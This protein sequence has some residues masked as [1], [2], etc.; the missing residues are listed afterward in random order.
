MLTVGGAMMKKCRHRAV[1]NQDLGLLH[2]I[3]AGMKWQRRWGCQ[4]IL[5]KSGKDIAGRQHQQNHD[6]SGQKIES[7][8]GASIEL[9]GT[10]IKIS[11]AEVEI[12]GS[13]KV[14]VKGR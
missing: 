3:T 8:A 4:V 12:N 1:W 6:G 9:D 14:D 5:R 13:A 2:R 10:K 11:A 7:G